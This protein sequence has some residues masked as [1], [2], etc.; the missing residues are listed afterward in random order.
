MILPGGFGAAKN[1]CNF[2]DK[3]ADAIVHPGVRKLI[4]NMNEESKPIG[5]ICIAPV[6][7]AKVLGQKNIK[8]TIGSDIAT[9]SAIETMG[10]THVDC[11][12]EDIVI[13]QTNKIV[14]TPAYMLGPSIKD[15]AV[16][17]E[18]LV[19]KVLSMT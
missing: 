10:C 2:A 6:V 8:L 5:A 11:K 14:T 9:A 13:D 1:L 7:I 15:I 18:K 4:L 12:V 3:G 17:I 19:E 16:G